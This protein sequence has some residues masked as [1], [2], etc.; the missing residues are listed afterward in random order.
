MSVAVNVLKWE[1]RYRWIGQGPA[2]GERRGPRR[3][4]ATRFRR[5]DERSAPGAQACYDILDELRARERVAFALRYME[6]M[7]VEEVAERMRISK[8]TAK[9]LIGRAVEKVSQRVG[10]NPDLSSYFLGTGTRGGH[11]T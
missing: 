3:R 2:V 1:L 7:T 8:S 6:E 9:R 4:H 5:G 10:K 11:D